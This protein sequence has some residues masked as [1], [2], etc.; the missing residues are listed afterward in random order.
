MWKAAP[1][2]GH[3]AVTPKAGPEERG[4]RKTDGPVC[5]LS[6]LIYY[7]HILQNQHGKLNENYTGSQFKLFKVVT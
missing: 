1:E 5:N 4:Q 6:F 2:P 7:M 3:R